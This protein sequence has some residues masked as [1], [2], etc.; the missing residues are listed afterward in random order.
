MSRIGPVLAAIV[1]ALSCVPSYGQNPNWGKPAPAP[2]LPAGPSMLEELYRKSGKGMLGEKEIKRSSTGGVVD[3][4]VAGLNATTFAAVKDAKRR[5][6]NSSLT[7]DDASTVVRA[8]LQDDNIDEGESDLLGELTQSQFRGITVTLAGSSPDKVV[9][10]PTSGNAKKLLQESIS[11][12]LSLEYA[13]SQ[14]SAGWAA[15]TMV[16]KRSSTEEAR[17]LHFVAGKLEA[18]WG[19]SNQ[20]NAY[21]PFRD[22][23]ST[24]I[25]YSGIPGADTN[26]GRTI[27][28]R[29]NQMVDAN[30]AGA[31]PDFLY[32]W[33]K[34]GG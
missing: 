20:A 14:G 17:V 31:V 11:P 9:M 21:K 29:A 10:H 33:I 22:L 5:N 12:P 30:T 28:F 7:F 2:P 24:M 13:W 16:Y 18:E 6:P 8:I 32:N 15:I 27:L 19:R 26:T 1:L 34:P 3:G 23:N 25:G 4:K